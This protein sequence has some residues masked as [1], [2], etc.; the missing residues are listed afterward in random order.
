MKIALTGGSTGIGAEVAKKLTAKGHHVTAFDITE[1]AEN[2]ARWIKTDLNDSSSIEAALGQADAP[3]D[4]LINN[5]GIPPR[6]GLEAAILGVNFFGFRAFSEGFLDKLSEGASIVNVAS[7]AGAQWR[8]NLDEVKAL[9]A[10]SAEEV[11]GF[12]EAHEIEHVR[13]Y[14]L[15][16]EA[17]IAYTMSQTEALVARGL[18][19]NSVSPAAVSTGILDD[20]KAAFGAKAANSIARAGRPGHPQEIA[21]VIVYLASNES[22]WIKGQDIVIDGG[23][24]AMGMSDALGLNG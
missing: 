4:A 18:R 19:M 5:A 11:S 6:E 17:V 8:E 15:S 7:R 21:D 9:L 13:A 24:S 14:N 10:C 23:M 1:P 20:F 12:I 3:Y 22:A 16:K 2:V